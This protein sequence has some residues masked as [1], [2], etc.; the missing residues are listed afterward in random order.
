VADP[1]DATLARAGAVVR[2][3]SVEEV[4]AE[5]EEARGRLVSSA[6]R[7]Q[8]DLERAT[9]WLAPVRKHPWLFL[10]GA[11]ATGLLIA[12]LIPSDD[13]DD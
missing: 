3:P 2:E 4:Q 10:A 7:V 11:F 13:A 12:S 8:D 9:A 5:V 6:Q 1:R